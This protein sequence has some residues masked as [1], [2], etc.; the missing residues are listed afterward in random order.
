MDQPS[1]IRQG[2]LLALCC[3][4]AFVFFAFA[5]PARAD[6]NG[7]YALN[8]WTLSNMD[9]GAVTT[10]GCTVPPVDGTSS[11]ANDPG[12][13]VTPDN[14]TSIVLTGPNDGNGFLG[15]T[16]FIVAASAPGTVEFS[17]SYS[18]A[19]PSG[20]DNAGYL[21]DGVFTELSNADGQSGVAKF[22]VS[23]GESFGFCMGT[24]DNLFE[25]GVLTVSGFSAPGQGKLTEP[26]ACGANAAN[27]ANPAPEP[28]TAPITLLFL[29]MVSTI[30]NQ[31][32]MSRAGLSKRGA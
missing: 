25:P 5:Q 12:C 30:V 15:T 29:V 13:F 27:P 26:T 28:G 10:N 1:K 14:G 18:S 22:M 8:N 11:N 4:L 16:E 21:L 19:D 20:F 7:D 24:L 23:A 2:S 6:F 17:W 9:V 31:R 32:R 3:A